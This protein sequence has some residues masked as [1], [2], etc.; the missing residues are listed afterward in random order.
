MNK[1]TEKSIEMKWQ[2]R[3]ESLKEKVTLDEIKTNMKSQEESLRKKMREKMIQSKRNKLKEF[4]EKVKE[5][6]IQASKVSD[7]FYAQC[8]RL[9][10]TLEDMDKFSE[11][12][13][14]ESSNTQLYG[15]VGIRIY[16]SRSDDTCPEI[17]V[18]NGA[19]VEIIKQLD[20]PYEEFVFEAL[21]CLT[22]I[23]SG[24]DCDI[25]FLNSVR[26]II[27][28]VDSPNNAIQKQAI[29][30]IG[31]LACDSVYLRDS[32]VTYDGLNILTNCLKT[33]K[34]MEVFTTTMF[35]LSN[36]VKVN[37]IPEFYE[38]SPILDCIFS[39]LHIQNCEEYLVD[40]LFI[41]HKAT[42]NYRKA[43]KKLIESGAL[44]YIVPY[45]W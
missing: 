4:D 20:S 19:V 21:W 11:C 41:L 27:E 14:S 44:K 32:I 2:Q 10:P 31:N 36:F 22:N 30:L 12:L 35:A 34:S 29:W 7:M 6:S 18:K 26:R 3:N 45:I 38:L 13:R 42:D 24:N 39:S 25:Y 5:G 43:V 16:L 28:L 15:L 17:L 1:I 37:P 23:S 40:A 33:T 8:E 9:S